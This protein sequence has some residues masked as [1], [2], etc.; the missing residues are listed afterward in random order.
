MAEEIKSWAFSVVIAVAVAA[1]VGLI[2]ENSTENKSIKFLTALFVL[3]AFL[4]PFAGGVIELGKYTDGINE[5]INSYKKNADIEQRA[6]QALCSQVE[7]LI[8]TELNSLNEKASDICV[9]VN[10]D[11]ENNISIESIVI[12]LNVSSEESL[13]KINEFIIKNFGVAPEVKEID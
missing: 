10:I 9:S 1:V 2:G 11:E 4:S 8:K 6:A 3:L 5:Q 7:A 13:N 12:Y